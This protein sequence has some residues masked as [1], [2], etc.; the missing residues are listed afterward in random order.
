MLAQHLHTVINFQKFAIV[1]GHSWERF[2][3]TVDQVMPRKGET[4]EMPLNDT[5]P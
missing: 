5:R 2:M 3:K 1:N 4:L